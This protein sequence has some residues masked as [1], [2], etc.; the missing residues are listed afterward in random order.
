MN[1]IIEITLF[2]TII[3]GISSGIGG[4]LCSL[5]NFKNK[6]NLY[7]L[8]QFTAGI[9]T[10]IVCFDMLPKS[11]EITN[12]WINII[13]VIIGIAFIYLLNNILNRYNNKKYSYNLI[14]SLFIMISM[15][16]HNLIEGL[17][18]GASFCYSFSMG[19]SVIIAIILHDIPEGVIVGM[20]NN[21]AGMNK[22]RNIVNTI[23]V[24][25]ITGIGALVGGIIGNINDIFTSLSLSIASGVML[26]I[27]SCELIPSLYNEC[28]NKV[29]NISY[30]IG[31]LISYIIV[32]M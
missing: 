8:Q 16:F 19:L 12:V 6:K 17:A 14:M 21:I 22:E 13:G 9:M 29:I 28:N 32:Y 5:K 3:G 31:I 27:I 10:G 26:Y 23:L 11:F 2:V 30:I 24:G 25:S 7:S 18:I 1:K 4:I 15:A 20:S